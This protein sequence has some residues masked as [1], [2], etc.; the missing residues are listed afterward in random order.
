M[1]PVLKVREQDHRLQISLKRPD[2]FRSLKQ[3]ESISLDGVCM[4]LEGFDEGHLRFSAAPETL[5]ITGWNLE[6]LKGRTF[7]LERSLTLQSAV[8]GH[9]V[10]GH[11]EGRAK[12][13]KITKQGE[14]LIVQIRLPKKFKKFF[15]KKGFI[16]LNGVSLTVNKIR[17]AVLELCLIPET[18]K[19]TN[20][21]SLKEGDFLNFE[22]DYMAR[23]LVRENRVYMYLSWSIFLFLV[24]FC[25]SFFM[26]LVFVLFFLL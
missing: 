8:G 2:S 25:L 13:K 26:A 12:V 19:R 17:G 1:A 4:T 11:V 3:G 6:N 20:L 9:F 15:W 14:S 10:T 24:I 7:N 18:L 21:S 23:P 22:A 16:A 5:Q